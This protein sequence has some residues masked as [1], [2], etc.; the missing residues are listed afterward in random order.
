[1]KLLETFLSRVTAFNVLRKIILSEVHGHKFYVKVKIRK[2][3]DELINGNWYYAFQI[4]V[5]FEIISEDLN[6]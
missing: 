2:G 5:K 3:H 1:M 6:F 4:I